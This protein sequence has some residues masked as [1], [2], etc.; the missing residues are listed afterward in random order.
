M[1]SRCIIVGLAHVAPGGQ[2]LRDRGGRL[3]GRETVTSAVAGPQLVQVDGVA[4][5]VVRAS[6]GRG[7]RRGWAIA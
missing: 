2:G 6:R 7:A 5:P 4:H 1:V 3:G